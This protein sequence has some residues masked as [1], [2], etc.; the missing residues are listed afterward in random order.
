MKL[1]LNIY[2]FFPGIGLQGKRLF[3]PENC[4]CFRI[5]AIFRHGKQKVYS[6]RNFWFVSGLKR[7]KFLPELFVDGKATKSKSFKRDFTPV[8]LLHTREIVLIRLRFFFVEIGVKNWFRIRANLTDIESFLLSYVKK[9]VTIYF[10]FASS[11]TSND[12]SAYL[13]FR[14][15]L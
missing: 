7:K 1:Y 12:S 8:W 13:Q 14:I 5:I 6:R 9:Y 15:L 3:N 11:E 10:F 2:W 4:D